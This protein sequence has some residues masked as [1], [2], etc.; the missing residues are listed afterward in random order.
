MPRALPRGMDAFQSPRIFA[1]FSLGKLAESMAVPPGAY[2][3][4]PM[5]MAVL[6]IKSCEKF[7]VNAQARVAILQN[8]AMMEILFVRLQRSTRMETGKAK[9]RIDQYT[10]DTSRPH[11]ASVMPN[12][13]FKNGNSE[14]ITMRSM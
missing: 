8:I 4:S 10:L 7:F 9:T 14:T 3:A 13:C 2:P 12:S 5:P 11:W 1:L 6:A